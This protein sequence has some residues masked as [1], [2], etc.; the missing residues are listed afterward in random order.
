MEAEDAA[1]G[2]KGGRIVWNSDRFLELAKIC[3]TN[4][5]G[6]EVERGKK[7]QTCIRIAQTLNEA[8]LFHKD[9]KGALNDR[10][11]A[12]NFAKLKQPEFVIQ[13]PIFSTHAQ[14]APSSGSSL[15]HSDQDFNQKKM[16]SPKFWLP[17][18]SQIQITS[19]AHEKECTKNTVSAIQQPAMQTKVATQSSKI[20][21]T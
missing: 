6:L 11:V 18:K 3:L 20:H 8:P 21:Q 12:T 2:K 4:I 15:H 5:D 13:K 10:I 16:L 9:E 14:A 19:S 17:H 7:T 1:K